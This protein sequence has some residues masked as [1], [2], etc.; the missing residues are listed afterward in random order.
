MGEVG[1]DQDEKKNT[2]GEIRGEQ[3]GEKAGNEEKN[4]NDLVSSSR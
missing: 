3:T 2:H 1:K 4:T